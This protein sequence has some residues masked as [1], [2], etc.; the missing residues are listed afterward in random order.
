M[1]EQL[2]VSSYCGGGG[3]VGVG[4]RPDGSVT[5]ADTKLAEGPRLRFTPEEW[6]A[7]VAGVKND[8]FDRTALGT[9]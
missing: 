6:D 5:V 3:C 9:S 4:L 8:E 7:F 1:N 2:R